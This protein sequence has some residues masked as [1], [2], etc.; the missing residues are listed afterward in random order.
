MPTS[1]KVSSNCLE[2]W[3]T[4][5]FEDAFLCELMDNEGK[6]PLDDLCS[7]RGYHEDGS[8]EVTDLKLEDKSTRLIKGSVH[9]SFT[10][11][12]PTGCRDHDWKDNVTDRI[13]FSLDLDSGIV[14]LEPPRLRRQY[15]SDEF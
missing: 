1:F 13:Y 14:T 4:P 9:V 15:E 7:S 12:S 3:D 8:A 10:E 6:L 5:E 2:K 11:L